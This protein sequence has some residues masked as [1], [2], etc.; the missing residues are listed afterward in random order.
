[1]LLTPYRCTEQRVYANSYFHEQ[2]IYQRDEKASLRVAMENISKRES[3][4]IKPLKPSHAVLTPLKI[5]PK[6]KVLSPAKPVCNAKPRFPRRANPRSA[7]FS[8]PS[9]RLTST[10]R[11]PSLASP[12][13]STGFVACETSCT[14]SALSYIVRQLG[15]PRSSTWDEAGSRTWTQRFVVAGRSNRWMRTGYV[16]RGTRK[17]VKQEARGERRGGEVNVGG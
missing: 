16:E 5:Q 17:H 1:M 10:A 2:E 11:Q 4:D 13:P 6:K 14:R 15:L 3:T 9:A 7:C 8:N 12:K